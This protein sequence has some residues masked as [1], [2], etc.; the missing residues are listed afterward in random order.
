MSDNNLA[1]LTRRY[2]DVRND[3]HGTTAQLSQFLSP[4]VSWQEMPN[5]FFAP[6]GRNYR[7]QETLE[8]FQVAQKYL[9]SQQYTINQMGVQ[10]ETVA[11]QA[12]W[13]GTVA[14]AMGPFG[15]GDRLTCQVAIFLTFQ[16][17]KVLRQ[18]EYPCYQPVVKAAKS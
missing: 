5:S 15:V 18:V 8:D 12:T 4:E 6:E 7:F 1:E 9:H 16:D 14:V 2:F 10:G 11:L 13:Q 3:P 17:G